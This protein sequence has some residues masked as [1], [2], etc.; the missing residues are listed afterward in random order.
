MMASQKRGPSWPDSDQLANED[1]PWRPQQPAG[2]RWHVSANPNPNPNPSSNPNLNI[3]LNLDLDLN[4]TR[5]L[6]LNPNPNPS[7]PGKDGM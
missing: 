2:S 5:N 6:H 1:L 3:N 7:L 4:L